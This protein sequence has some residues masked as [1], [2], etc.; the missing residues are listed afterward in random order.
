MPLGRPSGTA[1]KN[2]VRWDSPAVD[3]RDVLADLQEVDE[4]G[5]GG[6]A[7]RVQVPQDLGPLVLGGVQGVEPGPDPVGR[8]LPEGG[9]GRRA[10]CRAPAARPPD[11]G[12]AAV[13]PVPGVGQQLLKT[14]VL[15]VRH[16]PVGLRAVQLGDEFVMR[17]AQLRAAGGLPGLDLVD[18]RRD[19]LPGPCGRQHPASDQVGDGAGRG[20]GVAGE[21]LGEGVPPAPVDRGEQ[22]AE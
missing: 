15:V 1:G 21:P 3:L 5:G 20:E 11:H 14:Q 6:Q 2:S 9:A 4:V 12:V 18:R 22:L 10:P 19:E 17:P 7:S 13:E 8:L 16:G